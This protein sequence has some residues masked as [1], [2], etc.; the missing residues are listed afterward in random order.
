MSELRISESSIAWVIV[1]PLGSSAA[2]R[3][4]VSAA[5]YTRPSVR[6][7]V[8][9]SVVMNDWQLTSERNSCSELPG[10]GQGR[11]TVTFAAMTLAGLGEIS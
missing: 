10:G 3:L 4:L 9:G 7:P 1:S 8:S 5:V 2:T 11:T 6:A